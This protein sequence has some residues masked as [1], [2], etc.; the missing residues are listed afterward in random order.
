MTNF[1]EA[2][3]YARDTGSTFDVDKQFYGELKR[4]I[5]SNTQLMGRS[6]TDASFYPTNFL[7][8]K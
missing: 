7:P 6:L 5:W 3:N 8:D 2:E 1:R 4:R